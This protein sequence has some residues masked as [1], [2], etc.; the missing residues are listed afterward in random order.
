MALSDSLSNRL[1]GYKPHF[2]K[3]TKIADFAKSVEL[4]EV[5]KNE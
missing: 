5:A 1:A 2:L 4:D 3:M